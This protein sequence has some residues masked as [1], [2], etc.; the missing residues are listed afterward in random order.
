MA[1]IT[2]KNIEFK[3]GQKA[4]FGDNDDSAI[5]WDGP[6]GNLVITTTASGVD[7]IDAGHLVT[8]RYLEDYVDTVSGTIEH[9]N[10]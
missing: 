6:A 5:Y 8:K 7:P 9:G 4:I 10:L 3:D 2:S 1:K